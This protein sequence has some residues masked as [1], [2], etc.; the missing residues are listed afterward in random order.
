MSDFIHYVIIVTSSYHI[1]VTIEDKVLD[2]W[3]IQH[4]DSTVFLGKW[5]SLSSEWEIIFSLNLELLR[6]WGRAERI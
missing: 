6:A 1:T 2:M 3:L 4:F 5:E